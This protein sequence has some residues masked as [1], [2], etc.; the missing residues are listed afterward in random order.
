MSLSKSYQQGTQD[1]PDRKDPVTL[2]I[3]KIIKADCDTLSGFIGDLNQAEENRKGLKK[4]YETKKRSFYDNEHHYLNYRRLELNVG[5][6]LIQSST[7]IK[8][9]VGNYIKLSDSLTAALRTVVAGVKDAKKKFT[10]LRKASLDLNICL[11]DRCNCS[12]MQ[13][14][15]GRGPANCDDKTKK[16]IPAA[17]PDAGR[18]LNHLVDMPMHFLA[19][20]DTFLTA[21]ADVCGIQTFV[22][23]NSLD[24]LQL[25]FFNSAKTFN[26]QVQSKVTQGTTD[27]TQLQKD[28]VK[29]TTELT[30]ANHALYNRRDEVD[31]E[32]AT[33][34]YICNG[35]CND[36]CKIIAQNANGEDVYE[37]R[38]DDCK[39]AICSICQE[40]DNHYCQHEQVQENQEYK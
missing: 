5:V 34:E 29:A 31:A 16:P 19:D 9:S 35:D 11:T 30:S 33:I 36:D 14:L 32:V 7:E 8:Q 12:Q 26:T 20:C 28:L 37:G 15:V 38:F 18:I 39:K 4:L 1:G 24:Q 23:I 10:D 40:M 2:K 17:C 21:A 6:E 22:N 27:L 3:E 25:D 13:I